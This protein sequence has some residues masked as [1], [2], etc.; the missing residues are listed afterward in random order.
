MGTAGHIDHGKTAVIKMLT[1]HDCDTLKEEKIRGITIN[2]G[3]THMNLSENISLGIVDVPGHSDF[4]NTMVA[5][6]NGIDF[7]LMIIAADE[8]LMPQTHEH[9]QIMQMLEIK[10]GIIVLTK[11]DLVDDEL[12][13]LAIEEVKEFVAGTFLQ[14]SPIIPISNKTQSG[15]EILIDEIQKLALTIKT[16]K[17][18]INFRMFIDRVFQIKGWGTVVTGSVLSGELNKTD[19]VFIHPQK[20][21]GK[22]RRL[23]HHGMETDKIVAG[24][25]GSVN[26]TGIDFNLISR[27]NLIS[28]QILLT[29]K[30]IDVKIQLLSTSQDIG[31]WSHAIF[32]LGTF[33]TRAKIHLMDKD[34]LTSGDLCLAQIHLEKENNLQIG[35]NFILRNSSGE[36]TLGGGKIIDAHPLHHRR[37]RIKIL[38]QLKQLSAGDMENFIYSEVL[39]NQTGISSK[40]FS[41]LLN[42]EEAKINQTILK[43]DKDKIK[44]FDSGKEFLL[45]DIETINRWKKRILRHL[46]TYHKR[47][48]LDP[49]GR[50]FIEIFSLFQIKRNETNL[51]IVRNILKEL[52]ENMLLKKVD[53][54]WVLFEH[55]VKL[56]NDEKRMIDKFERILYNYQLQV[57]LMSEMI[58][59]AEKM[60]GNEKKLKQILF[61]LVRK[62]FAYFIDGN[63]IHKKIVNRSREKLI[64]YLSSDVDG[65]TVSQF[66]DLISGNRKISLLLLN[67]FD[68]EGVTKRI[69][70]K[71]YLKGEVE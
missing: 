71:R 60:G 54:S 35:D 26:I 41:E 36:M 8:G 12:L 37:R 50:D 62:K 30:L 7:V 11:T 64:S 48:P 19:D 34:K 52:T 1:D 3:F 42:I 23:E 40:Y 32:L 24:D 70:D 17:T 29:T 68:T 2:L 13:G 69:G 20:I 67:R 59:K 47:N 28:N 6:A 38:D 14:N 10:S 33:K 49:G 27:G 22:I 9:L 57:P 31:L 44:I 55:T 53:S 43:T 58:D 18:G 16:N 21:G 66:R 15:K 25:R 4:I 39:K 65:I 56:S 61:Y 51:S 63:Y 45:I 5:G 46:K